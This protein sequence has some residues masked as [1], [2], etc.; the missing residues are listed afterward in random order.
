MAGVAALTGCGSVKDWD[1]RSA[2]GGA[3]STSSAAEQATFNRPKPDNRG[4]ISYPGYQV[5]VAK[6]GDTVASIANRLN[7]SPGS[8]ARYNAIAVDTPLNAGAVIAL[9]SRVA[10]PSPA[11]GSAT[12]GPLTPS[13]GAV[14]ITQLATGAIN[15]AQAGQGASG[16]DAAGASASIGTSALPSPP[17]A[18]PAETVAPALPQ[19]MKSAPD[20]TATQP[21]K[22]KVKR[23]ETAYSIA[24]LYNV[25]VRALA[26]WNGLGPNLSVH[27]GQ[28]LLIPVVDPS[29]SIK[30][31]G[32]VSA[33]G[34]Q[35][36]TPEPPSAATP[37]P[38][39]SPPPA[40]AP[41]AV[42]ATAN[43]GKDRTSASASKLL[44]P[45]SGMI[46]R[47]YDPA[48]NR[49]GIDISAAAG[50]AVQA[51]AD[52]T[53]ATVTS[54]TKGAQIVVIRHSGN[55]LTVYKFLTGITVTK[56]ATVTRGQTIGRVAQGNPPQ[57]YFAV[58]EGTDSVDPTKYIQ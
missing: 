58:F 1:M 16:T 29:R 9:P 55:L 32:A 50:T 22:H 45:V 56:G 54:D 18:K 13:N 10:E 23:G 41:V 46:I 34:Q 36:P 48:H 15:R 49:K 30:A 43:L 5:V 17:A 40:S 52:G 44:M 33:P 11:T 42:P 47:P 57:L 24:R 37:L 12:T 6:P 35:S 8:V 53:V 20:T 7:L 21:I 3:F 27:E 4:V 19:P 51:A 14:D 38:T 28:V 25:P 2:M 39:T 31:A 26:D